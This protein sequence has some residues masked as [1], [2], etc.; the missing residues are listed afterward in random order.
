VNIREFFIS[1]TDNWSAK[2]LCLMLAVGLFIFQRINTMDSKGFDVPLTIIQNS[3][4]V[5]TKRLP[6]YVRVTVKTT[7]DDLSSI[8]ENDISVSVDLSSYSSTGVY[9]VPID[10][11]PSVSVM[12]LDTIEI[13]IR[14]DDLKVTLDK[15]DGKYFSV[16]PI[17]KGSVA[18]GYDLAEQVVTPAKIWVEGPAAVVD[19]LRFIPT[20]QID[21]TGRSSDISRV[22]KI[23][24]LDSSLLTNTATVQYTAKINSILKT[25]EWREIPILFKNLD[26]KFKIKD[27]EYLGSINLQGN[28][29]LIENYKVESGALYADCSEIT[30]TGEYELPVIANVSSDFQVLSSDPS[31]IS[32]VIEEAE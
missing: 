1:I 26:K 27:G 28:I 2:I 17:Y 32:V 6:E 4:F 31:V 9:N 25:Y 13:N 23:G 10:L 19:S 3:E 5:P 15:K 8:S 21:I 24:E 16:Q 22:V 14:P 30:E 12:Y 7:K 20:E 11:H 18:P 29:L